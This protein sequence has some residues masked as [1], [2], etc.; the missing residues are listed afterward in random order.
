MKV[1]DLY[2]LAGLFE[3]DG[4]VKNLGRYGMG[5]EIAMTDLDVLENCQRLFG[6]IIYGPYDKNKGKGHN[7]K[8]MYS[9][10]IHKRSESYGILMTIYPLLG[11]RRRDRI[12]Q[13]AIKYLNGQPPN[14]K[15]THCPKGHEYNLE[16]TKI[17]NGKRYCKPCNDLY[18]SYAYR[19]RN[20]GGDADVESKV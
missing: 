10:N 13:A 20:K 14:G 12:K 11:Q 1:C 9:W 7:V 17:R 5:L 19:K 4:S 16:N 6:G 3:A 2:W 15:K 8:P 18:G